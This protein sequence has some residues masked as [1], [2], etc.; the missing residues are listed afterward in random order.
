MPAPQTR[1][2]AIMLAPNGARLT[3]KD[4]PAI[5]VTIPETVAAIAAGRDAGA[6]A[7]HLHVRDENAR[8]LLDADVYR[9]SMAAV[10]E[11]LGASFPIQVTTESVGLYTPPEQMAMVRNLSPEFASVGMR[12]LVNDDADIEAARDF[13]HW[14]ADNGTGIQHILYE[15][16][17][18]ATL[19]ELQAKGVLPAAP[20]TMI[21]VLGRYTPGQRS[22]PADLDP[23]LQA[24]EQQ[25]RENYRQWMICAFGQLETDCLLHAVDCG[26]HVRIGFENNRL[27]PD[28]T[29][30][31][32]NA[33]RV[34][35]LMQA[36]AERGVGICDA[37]A[38]RDVLGSVSS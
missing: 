33:H 14:A 4:H 21:F 11:R 28:G 27:Q 5:P 15:P 13:Y 36:L 1:S 29:P 9:E 22:E 3:S 7:V 31:T 23:F 26:G 17:E 10:R 30:A 25:P 38:T 35:T 16:H 32:D 2:V 18:V 20:L 19:F 34:T 24:L 6:T 37:D 12:E 8:H